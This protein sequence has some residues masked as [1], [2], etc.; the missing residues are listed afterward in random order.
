MGEVTEL[1]VVRFPMVLNK[2]VIVNSLP[3]LQMMSSLRSNGNTVCIRRET[4][5]SIEAKCFA[6]VAAHF[7]I[8]FEIYHVTNDEDLT[9]E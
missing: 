9:N 8:A 1:N 5:E 6:N 2:L 7:N 3:V 4:Y